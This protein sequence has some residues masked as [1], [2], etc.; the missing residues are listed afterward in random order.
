MHDRAAP[1]IMF[2]LVTAMF[3]LFSAALRAVIPSTPLALIAA[4]VSCLLGFALFARAHWHPP[5]KMPWPSWRLGH[6][7]PLWLLLATAL[8]GALFGLCANVLGG[9]CAEL[10]PA[11]K[12]QAA[13]YAEGLKRLLDPERPWHYAA[14]VASVTIFAPLCEE[15]LFRGTLLPLQRER[16]GMITAALL[17]GAL[18]GFIHFN[19]MGMLPLSLLGAALA[20]LTMR[21]GSIWPAIACHLGVNTCNGVVVPL[22]SASLGVEPG[23]EEVDLSEL[24]AWLAML[25]P[26]SGAAL[27]ALVRAYAAAYTERRIR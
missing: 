7:G 4:E 14:A 2:L 3:L 1:Y 13:D 18:F 5:N 9:L 24:F 22:V 27:F 10:I 19:P 20:L 15:A 6:I 21:S 12:P 26:L 25:L 16:E 8:C 11:I 17:N 23:V